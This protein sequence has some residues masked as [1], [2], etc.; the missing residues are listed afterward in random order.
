MKKVYRFIIFLIIMFAF[1]STIY[2]QNSF[3]QADIDSQRISAG[4]KLKLRME[5]PLN[6]TSST[7]GDTFIATLV[8][9]VYV[10]NKIILPIGSVVRGTVLESQKSRRLMR[11]AELLLDFDHVVTPIGKQIPLTAMV[12]GYTYISD[13]GALA[14]DSSYTKAVDDYFHNSIDLAGII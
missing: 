7:Q 5:S 1:C 3:I 11:G 13:S 6:S 2:A 4:Q 8:N 10:G 14:T 9:D 12:T